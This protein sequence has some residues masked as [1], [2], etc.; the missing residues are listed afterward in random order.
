MIDY[1]VNEISASRPVLRPDIVVSS[2][3]ENG[4]TVFL[5]EDPLSGKFYEVG[6]REFGAIRLLDGSRTLQDVVSRSV[7]SHG[8]GISEQE[9]VSLIR[10]LAGA[11]LLSTSSDDQAQRIRREANEKGD[12]KK[13]ASKAQSMFFLRIPLGSPDRLLG[14]VSNATSWIPGWMIALVWLGVCLAGVA[15]YVEHY[16]R[17]NEELSGVLKVQNVAVF[18]I[19]WLVLKAI[20]EFCHGIVCKRL[21]GAVPEAGVSF[22]LFITP[23]AYVD[24]SSSI[25]FRNKWHRILVAAAGILGEFFVAS[26]ALLVWAKLEP[27]V[28]G[29]VLHQVVVISTVTTVL[30]NANPLMRFD[31][32]YIASDLLE[33]SNLYTKGQKAARYLLKK[34]FFGISGIR[35]PFSD[36]PNREKLVITGY[37]VASSLWKVVVTFGLFYGAT[38][39]FEGVGLLAA[40]IVG[41]VMII[42]GLFSVKKYFDRAAAMEKA[43][44]WMIGCRMAMFFVIAI[45][46]ATWIK[47]SPEV[48][49]VGI[50]DPGHDGELRVECPGFVEEI[51]IENGKWVEKGDAIITL[52]NSE[53][54]ADLENLKRELVQAEIRSSLYLTD[55][56]VAG[57]Q[58]ELARS[59]GL[60][61]KLQDLEVYVASL[62]IVAPRSGIVFSRDIDSLQDGYLQKGQVAA[63]IVDLDQREI[64]IAIP[65]S[66][67]RALGEVSRGDTVQ[68]FDKSRSDMIEAEVVA[69]RPQAGTTV[70]HPA[71]TTMG[72]GPIVVRDSYDGSGEP[73]FTT[74]HFIAVARLSETHLIRDGELVWVRFGN[75]N[76]YSLAEWGMQRIQ[77]LTDQG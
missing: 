8:A 11:N 60:K 68:V 20:H 44:I 10:M 72:G 7:N 5:L 55:S 32:Y 36:L 19:V 73:V 52:R 75:G 28:V 47:I 45:A 64:R 25:R 63:R 40:V 35:F 4:A 3:D 70:P 51:H 59:E 76:S 41:G 43:N 15:S 31:G 38:L 18:G 33:I 30:F 77:D 56:N 27:G 29:S 37:G 66:K 16:Q 21:G 53:V 62:S 12:G 48:K 23:L 57:A 2:R 1:S 49:A 24:A 69:V 61:R 6:E 71:I 46:A 50:F 17:F 22:L 74:P 26:V 67:M 39:M 42:S 65:Q 54:E 9:A 58:A 13:V 34:W 14:L